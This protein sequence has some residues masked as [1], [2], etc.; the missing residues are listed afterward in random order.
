MRQASRDDVE[1]VAAGVSWFGRAVLIQRNRLVKAKRFGSGKFGQQASCL[2]DGGVS[3]V[4]F[5]SFGFCI[6]LRC[7]PVEQ[8]FGRRYARADPPSSS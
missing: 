2:G 6:F 3:F 7:Q 1:S 8:D 5:A 4:G